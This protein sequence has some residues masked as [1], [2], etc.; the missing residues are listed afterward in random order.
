MPLEEDRSSFAV[1]DIVN[2]ASSW[3]N[4]H[5][6]FPNSHFIRTEGVDIIVG[7]SSSSS[8]PDLLGPASQICHYP[9]GREMQVCALFHHSLTIY[10]HV[11][12]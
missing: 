11:C 4:S 6:A 12:S 10:R 7:D 9:D 5:T 8:P 1:R 3:S 2:A